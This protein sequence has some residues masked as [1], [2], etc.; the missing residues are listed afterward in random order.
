M[1][2]GFYFSCYC[3]CLIF[4]RY[5]EVYTDDLQFPNM[6]GIHDPVEISKLTVYIR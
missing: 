6:C 5:L 1:N 2:S 4:I 3:I